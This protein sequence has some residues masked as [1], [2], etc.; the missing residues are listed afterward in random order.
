MK[1][2]LPRGTYFTFWLVMFIKTKKK[3]KQQQQQRKKRKKA[4]RKKREKKEENKIIKR[5]I[6]KENKIFGP[7]KCLNHVRSCFK[8]EGEQ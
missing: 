1:G 5:K 6:E 3:K 4:K 8:R 2:H 7:K